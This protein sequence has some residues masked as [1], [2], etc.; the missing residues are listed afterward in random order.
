MRAIWGGGSCRFTATVPAGT[1]CSRA[2]I[3]SSAGRIPIMR[4]ASRRISCSPRWSRR[5]SRRPKP[6]RSAPSASLSAPIIRR[7]RPM[8]TAPARSTSLARPPSPRRSS[9]STAGYGG[10]QRAQA[11]G[12]VVL[13]QLQPLHR[14]RAH[15]HRGDGTSGTVTQTLSG[16]TIS[17]GTAISHAP[18]RPAAGSQNVGAGAI[19][20][21]SPSPSPRRVRPA[22]PPP[23]PARE[24]RLDRGDVDLLHRH[25]RLHRPLGGGA[26][27]IVHRRGRTRGV[28]CQEKPQR[29]LHQPHM[30]RPAILSDRVQ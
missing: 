5:R 11:E 27:G 8:S 14:H 16:G 23:S 3:I 17:G 30:L 9:R 1:T 24:R 12:R 29:S 22:W 25:H 18:S 2:S 26:I 10:G 28:I 15:R 4:R 19:A 21:R 6:A 20:T 13:H 7:A